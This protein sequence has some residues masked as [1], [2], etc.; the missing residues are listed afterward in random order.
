MNS[1]VLSLGATKYK[2]KR[3]R[4]PEITVGFDPKARKEYLTGFHKRKVERKQKADDKRKERERLQ[5][6]EDRASAR[7]AR[8]E[9]IEERVAASRELQRQEEDEEEEEEVEEEEKELEFKSKE[10]RSV[11]KIEAIQLDDDL[12]ELKKKRS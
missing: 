5:R 9:L 1:N 4:Q 11:V 3:L 7:E 2:P 8:K 10:T 6:I 12:H